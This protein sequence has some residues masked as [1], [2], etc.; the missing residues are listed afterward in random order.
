MEFKATMGE[1]SGVDTTTGCGR[2]GVVRS[3]AIRAGLGDG[4]DTADER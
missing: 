1:E 3:T 4:F 2:S